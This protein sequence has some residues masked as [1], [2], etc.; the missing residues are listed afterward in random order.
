[1]KC[2]PKPTSIVADGREV[3]RAHHLQSVREEVL[4]EYAPA[5]EA[6]NWFSRFLLH[7]RMRR[8]IERRLKELASDEAVYLI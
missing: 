3:L 4:R 6:A 1:M 2:E 8:E 7:R 5:L